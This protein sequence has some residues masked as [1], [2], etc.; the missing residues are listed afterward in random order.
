VNAL[1]S[2]STAS[3]GTSLSDAAVAFD[4]LVDYLRGHSSIVRAFAMQGLAA[5]ASTDSS[6]RAKILP[7]LEE[8][9]EIGTP[10][11]RALGRTLLQHLNR[12]RAKA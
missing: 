9:A 12:Q 8:L 5:L 11:M 1:A 6:V 4:I 2:F 10:A 7:L 3:W